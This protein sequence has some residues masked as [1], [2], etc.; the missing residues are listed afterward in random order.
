MKFLKSIL[1]AFLGTLLALGIV[2]FLMLGLFGSLVAL[3]SSQ[4]AVPAKAYLEIDLSAG[5]AEQN[6]ED[7]YSM[8]NPFS[9]GSLKSLGYYQVVQSIDF[10]ANDPAVPFIYVKCDNPAAGFAHL[11]EIR[12]ALLRFRNS[13]KPVIAF[14]DNFTQGGYYVATAADKIYAAP[15]GMTQ[16]LGLSA[17]IFFLKD[18]LDRAHVEVQLIRHGKYKSA[19]EQ[20][21]ASDISD[22]NREQQTEMLD[23]MWNVIAGAVCESRG[24][25]R[26]DLDRWVDALETDSPE[27]LLGHGLIDGIADREEL[28]EKLCSLFGTEDAEELAAVPV[29]DYAAVRI[30]PNVKARDKIAVLYADGQIN[31]AEGEGITSGAMIRELKKIRKD[32]AV[33]ALVLRVNSPGGSAQ[34][35][36]LIRRELALVRDSVPVI[37][38]FGDYAA[39][40]GYWISAEADRIFTNGLTLTGSIGVFSLIPSLGGTV[41]NLAQVNPVTVRTHRHSD[42][43]SLMRPL[44]RTETASMQQSVEQVYGAFLNIVS[45]GRGMTPEE[46]D[47]IAQG[48]VWAG[49]DAVR[50]GLADRIGGLQEAIEYAAAAAGTDNYQLVQYP[51]VRTAFEKVMERLGQASLRMETLSE[52]ERFLQSVREDLQQGSRTVY[53]RLPYRLEMK[54]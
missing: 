49:E 40:G 4:P 11:E 50:I 6:S 18:L 26:A 53:A 36:E 38:S 30:R 47:E 16:L 17:Q 35:A 22:A 43:F 9:A 8:L 32:P 2:F 12:N 1:A 3:G 21:I 10:A 31:G 45:D 33:K 25:D 19:G 41:R 5:Y 52:P 37:V 24:V 15:L 13:G 34:T 7:P 27:K 42:M 44:D 48:R 29:A 14:A 20:F 51:A 23:G 54:P 39:S 46:V 28:E